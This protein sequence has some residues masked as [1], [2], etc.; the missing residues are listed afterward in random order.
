M[1]V[2]VGGE[3]IHWGGQI[4]GRRMSGAEN[5]RTWA[6]QKGKEA[7]S[8]ASPDLKV[9][10]RV[11]LCLNTEAFLGGGP[12]LSVGVAIYVFR[13]SPGGITS[14]L[15]PLRELSL[16]WPVLCSHCRSLEVWPGQHGEGVWAISSF[17]VPMAG[18]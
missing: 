3:E 8:W 17:R 15:P 12:Q 13:Y 16:Q 11:G 7:H 5:V 1:A 4:R 9:D 2:A 14:P 18:H 6:W 10:L